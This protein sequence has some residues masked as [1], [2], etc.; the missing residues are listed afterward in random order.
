MEIHID[1]ADFTK[2]VTAKI[3]IGL[4]NAVSI[5]DAGTGEV[6]IS[7]NREDCKRLLETASIMQLDIA[8]LKII[9]DTE[10][11]IMTLPR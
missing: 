11:D 5:T 8:V 10:K 4:E 6:I 7:G 3:R 1:D 9:E 2:A